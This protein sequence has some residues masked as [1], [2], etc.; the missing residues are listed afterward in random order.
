MNWILYTTAVTVAPS[1]L[2]IASP[3]TVKGGRLAAR[4]ASLMGL[5]VTHDSL[6][7]SRRS[8]SGSR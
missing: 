5:S 6:G 1:V 3:P 4:A 8:K 7:G 2:V